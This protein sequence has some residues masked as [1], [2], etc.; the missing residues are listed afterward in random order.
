MNN[1]GTSKKRAFFMK[2]YIAFIVT[3]IYMIFTVNPCLALSKLY[4]IYNAD[5]SSISTQTERIITEK[6]YKIQKKNPYLAIPFDDPNDY[7][8]IVFQQD[9]KNLFYY[10]ESNNSSKKLNKAIIKN[11]KKQDYTYSESE[12]AVQINNFSQIARRTLTGEKKT[13]SFDEP[14]PSSPNTVTTNSPKAQPSTTLSGYVGK[15]GKGDTLDVYLQ[16]A[17]NTATAN[18]GDNIIGVLNSDWK[19]K[20][21]HIIAAQGSI[22]YG[23]VIKAHHAQYAMRNGFV[24]ITFNKIV[25]PDGKT[26]DITTKQIDFNVSNDGIVSSTAQKVATSALVGAAVGALFGLIGGGGA[27]NVWQ[28]AAIGAG[29]GGG[30][31]LITSAADKGIDAEIPAF[32]TVEVVLQNNIDVVINY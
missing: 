6:D 5:K 19:T 11:I 14:K 3:L 1:V 24:R 27:E 15:V 21:N 9:G 28:G 20:D 8:V 17:I 26:Y 25:T 4:Y 18:E 31:A 22:L 2:R 16:N 29:M 23:Q 12:N 13:Y 10:Y 32:T 7:A 30:G